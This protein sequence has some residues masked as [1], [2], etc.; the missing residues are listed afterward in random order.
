[1]RHLGGFGLGED[2]EGG[3]AEGDDVGGLQHFR[4]G[5][6]FVGGEGVEDLGPGFLLVPGGGEEVGHQEGDDRFKKRVAVGGH[7]SVRGVVA[8]LF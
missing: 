4:A 1:M 5:A 7:R 6:G 3:H 2:V 8:C